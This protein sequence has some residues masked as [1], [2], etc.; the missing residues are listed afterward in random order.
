MTADDAA[1]GS[2]DGAARFNKLE[3]RL[4]SA[5]GSPG[6]TSFHGGEVRMTLEEF[7][8]LI[9]IIEVAIDT[10]STT[11]KDVRDHEV[12]R[13]LKTRGL[14]TELARSRGVLAGLRR[15]AEEE[16]AHAGALSCDAVLELLRA[17][18]PPPSFTLPEIGAALSRAADDV[19][20]LLDEDPFRDGVN[21][22][23]NAAGH[24]LEHP[25]DDLDDAI[26]A[27]YDSDPEEVRG[28]IQQ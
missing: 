7:A 10:C 21:L 9:G 24:Y 27:S 11:E 25:D 22:V 8:R 26:G 5:T 18:A 20:E 1:P 12:T 23:V 6:T 3:D 4:S 28:W 16:R 2:R 15:L 19:L 17:V 14:E 13:A